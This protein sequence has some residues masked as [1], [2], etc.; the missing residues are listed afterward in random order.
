MIANSDADDVELGVLPLRMRASKNW[1][2]DGY[3]QF[4]VSLSWPDSYSAFDGDPCD[5]A[6]VAYGDGGVAGHSDGCCTDGSIA[7]G[8]LLTS[9]SVESGLVA[10][11][12]G[13]PSGCEELVEDW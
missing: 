13:G 7:R 11:V 1:R 3:T 12:R 10:F 8:I 5:A 4:P 2:S 9:R 6:F